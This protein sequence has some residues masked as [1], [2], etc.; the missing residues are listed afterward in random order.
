MNNGSSNAPLR[1][2]KFNVS[3]GGIRVPF[4]LRWKGVLPVREYD[5]PVISLDL[6]ATALAL[7]GGKA[8]KPLDGVNLM[9]F[10]RGENSAPPHEAL[11][12]RSGGGVLH[13]VRS[14]AMKLLRRKDGALELYDFAT[15]PGE[16]HDLAAT[17]PAEV[18]RLEALRLAWNAQ[19]V[20]P[21][22]PPLVHEPDGDSLIGW[23]PPKTPTQ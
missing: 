9:P 16:R 2:G 18:R 14:G 8:V 17:K 23:R 1:G 20:P 11:Y 13:A 15:D 10:L 12:W 6:V 3:E 21:L 19:L 22:F 5:Q 4:V 7:A